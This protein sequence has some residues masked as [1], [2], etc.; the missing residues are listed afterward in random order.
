MREIKFRAKVVKAIQVS[1]EGFI[2]AGEWITWYP[3]AWVPGWTESIDKE[4]VSQFTGLKDKN[5]VDIY[6]GDIVKKGIERFV[7]RHI[8]V[9]TIRGW[10]SSLCEVIGN[11][12]E[13]PKLLEVTS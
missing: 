4:S 1:S 11:I 12:F 10:N 7:V 9:Q 6:E 13:N 3:L 5:G 2:P 8:D